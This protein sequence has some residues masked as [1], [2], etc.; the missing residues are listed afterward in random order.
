[1]INNQTFIDR[2]ENNTG[3]K[4]F[5]YFLNPF[6]SEEDVLRLSQSSKYGQN[7]IFSKFVSTTEFLLKKYDG[8]YTEQS[9]YLTALRWK[10]TSISCEDSFVDLLITLPKVILD[11]INCPPFFKKNVVECAKI[12]QRMLFVSCLNQELRWNAYYS[13]MESFI[14]ARDFEQADALVSDLRINSQSTWTGE[15]VSEEHISHKKAWAKLDRLVELGLWKEAKTFVSS[16]KNK[17]DL[18]HRF[19]HHVKLFRKKNARIVMNHPQVKQNGWESARI[20]IIKRYSASI[21][22]KIEPKSK[23][24]Q[25]RYLRY[26]EAIFD[27]QL[28]AGYITEADEWQKNNLKLFDKWNYDIRINNL[29]TFEKKILFARVKECLNGNNFKKLD[30]LGLNKNLLTDLFKIIHDTIENRSK[31]EDFAGALS[32]IEKLR[33]LD[34]SAYHETTLRFIVTSYELAILMERKQIQEVEK[35]LNCDKRNC[36]ISDTINLLA[37]S[38]K[39]EEA[40]DLA[41]MYSEN[42]SIQHKDLCEI[43]CKP[44]DEGDFVRARE[45]AASLPEIYK[46]T[47]YQCIEQFENNAIFIKEAV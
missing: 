33:Q 41:L 19:K 24:L 45:L 27:M 25:N 28:E 35:I 21:E 26:L 37:K 13:I 17:V 8:R 31:K 43:C 40:R 6:L 12:G 10:V 11:Q 46:K 1:M 5:E 2:F 23:N 14:K 30:E 32:L 4:F 9:K 44:I 16:M 22:N 3:G 29:N 39:L 47:V 15:Q 38:R 7:L 18:S 34:L 42:S 20:E 36:Y